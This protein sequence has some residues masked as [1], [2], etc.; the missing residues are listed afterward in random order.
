MYSIC[1]CKR[2]RIHLLKHILLQYIY[3]RPYIYINVHIP[4]V[5]SHLYLYLC[6][7]TVYLHGKEI[8]KL[9]VNFFLVVCFV[10]LYSEPEPNS[11]YGSGSGAKVPKWIRFRPVPV[12]APQRW[13]K[14]SLLTN[15]GSAVYC[16][17]SF[18]EKCKPGEETKEKRR[19]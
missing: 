17:M 3:I 4:S 13:K 1:I 5:Y 15:W 12:P 14:Y 11:E 2:I 7:P 19:K 6:I 10:S 8:I 9:L 16:R 18:E